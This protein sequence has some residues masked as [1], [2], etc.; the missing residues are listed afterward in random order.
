MQTHR[1]TTPDTPERLDKWLAAALP[2]LSRAQA[3][4][5]IEAGAV[6]TADGQTLSQPSK[7]APV[8]AE[9]IIAIP[10][11]TPSGVIAQAE[12]DFGIVYDDP[13]L[14]VINKPPGLTTHPAPAAPDH[15][16]VNG[17][18]ARFGAS[19]SGIGGVQRPGIVHRLDKDTSGLMVVAKHDRAHRHL[20]EQLQTRSLYREY[21]ALCHGMP[22]PARGTIETLIGRSPRDRKKMA[23]LASGG[24]SAVTHYHSEALFQD[25]RFSA[26]VCKLETG[27]THQIRVHLAH[28]GCPII[29]DP[30]YGHPRRKHSNHLTTDVQE[31]VWRFPRQAL[32]ARAIGFIHPDSGEAMRFDAPCPAD[33]E[34]LRHILEG[35]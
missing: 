24:K 20:S 2:E 11:A 1:L 31:A 8:G 6:T 13:H 27:R 3:K 4:A 14:I 25:G 10:E 29:G 22:K 23:V 33:M 18:L 26:V 9:I 16:L 28:I 12:V 21:I 5:L 19:L 30:V 7:P 15:T 17:L 35:T 34:A 32:H